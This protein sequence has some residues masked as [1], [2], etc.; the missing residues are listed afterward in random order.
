MPIAFITTLKDFKTFSQSVSRRKKWT[1]NLSCEK[2]VFDFVIRD[3]I[4]DVM[5]TFQELD[6]KLQTKL[7]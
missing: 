2:H 3:H 7:S 1:H 5:S 6:E 4:A